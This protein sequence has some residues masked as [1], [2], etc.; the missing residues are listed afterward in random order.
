MDPTWASRD[1]GAAARTAAGW[2]SS[3]G[4]T[5]GSCCTEQ[6]VNRLRKHLEDTT[7]DGARYQ[8]NQQKMRVARPNGTRSR[9]SCPIVRLKSTTGGICSLHTYEWRFSMP[10]MQVFL[11]PG[12]NPMSVIHVGTSAG[13]RHHNAK[14]RWEQITKDLDENSIQF[15]QAM[16]AARI[17]ANDEAV[18]RLKARGDELYRQLEEANDEI[19]KTYPTRSA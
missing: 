15:R 9:C 5:P 11:F 17:P 7:R 12:V 2:P 19:A 4:Y 16:S 14:I 13:Q 18:Q 6:T 1:R 8:K 3:T 10:T